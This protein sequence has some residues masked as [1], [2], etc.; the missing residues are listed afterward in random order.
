M[1]WEIILQ[2]LGIVVGAVLGATQVLER[3]PKSRATLK[4]DLE[5]LKLLDRSRSLP[6][7]AGPHREARAG[8]HRTDLRGRA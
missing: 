8:K 1:N 3:L 6:S 5:V 4:H 7:P 2:A